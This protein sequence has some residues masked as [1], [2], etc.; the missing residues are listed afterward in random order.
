MTV[1]RI[2]EQLGGTGKGQMTAL[3]SFDHA[4]QYA[5]QV[6]DPFAADPGQEKDLE[7]YF[8]E[9]LA[10]PFVE[11]VRARNAA[12][13]IRRYG[14][15]LF[16]QIFADPRA[17]AA[18]QQAIKQGAH[19]IQVE[20]AGSPSF[21][22]LH[23]ETLYD[24]DLKLPLSQHA[25]FI[26]QNVSTQV[27]P[28]PMRPSPTINM[29]VVVARPSGSRDIGYRTV[30]RP[31]VDEL[32]KIRQPV[33]ITLLRPG[34]YAALQEHLEQRT[35]KDGVGYYHVIHF[36]VHGGLMS[37]EQFQQT[38]EPGRR[39]YLY[40]GRFGRPDIEPY[41]GQ[42][43]YLLLE[44]QDDEQQA[45]PVEASE[46]AKLLQ[47]H[48]IPI[49]VLNACQSG[50]YIGEQET[51]LG[52]H[53]I[54]AGVQTVLAMAYSVTV[55]A[56]ELL[57][58]MLYKELLADNSLAGALCLAR[59][60]LANRK[61][62]RAYYNQKIELE[63]WVLPIVYQNQDVHFTRQPFATPQQETAFYEGLA[64]QYSASQPTYGFIGR[65][66]DILHIER[67]L[68][69]RR[70]LLLIQGMGGAGKTTL[71]HHLAAWW[72]RTGLVQNVFYFGYDERAWNRQQL[73]HRIAQTVFGQED[74]A[75]FQSRS[76]EVQQVQLTQ[77]LRS[78]RHLLILD[79]LESITGA[80]LA[81]R[82]TLSRKEQGNLQSLLKELVGGQ[83]LVVLGSR[84]AET[85]L[86]SNTFEDNRYELA[87][88]DP[89]AASLLS[90]RILERHN[91]TQYRKDKDLPALLKLLDGFPL[92]LEVVLANLARQ[93][94]TQ[95]LAALQA[96]D[97]NLN[98]GQS[99]QR[100]ENILRCIDYSHSNL[101]PEA[102]NLLLCLAPFTSVIFQS[103]VDQ[104]ISILKQQPALAHFP[105]DRL[106]EVLQEAEQW[107]LLSPDPDQPAFLRL[108]PTLPYFLRNRLSSEQ[109]KEQRAAI[110][111]AF[112]EH[113]QE[114]SQS[115]GA[116]IQSKE[117]QKQQVGYLIAQFEYE[118][119]F[120]ALRFALREN[121]SVILIY[122]VLSLLLQRNQDHQH[123]QELDT[124]LLEN[125]ETLSPQEL[126]GPRGEEF[127]RVLGTAANRQL[128]L[129]QYEDAR[130]SYQKVLQI[131][132]KVSLEER[133][134]HL[135]QGRTYHQLGRVAE[136][137]RKWEEA[138]G[139]YERALQIK[140]EYQDGYSQGRTYHQ[141]GIVAQEQRKWEEAKG[142]YER[143][144]QIYVEY[145]DGY[146][147]A[148]TYH[149][150]G[151]VAQEQRKW[152]EAQGYYERALQIKIEYQDGYSQG[153]TYHQ[154]GIVAQEQRKWEEAKGYYERALRIFVEYDDNY[155]NGIVMRSLARLQRASN[156]AGFV[157]EVASIVGWTLE[158]VEEW[159]Q[160]AQE[161]SPAQDEEK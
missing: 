35:R 89:E 24:P 25:P 102:Q 48:Q 57:M 11:P 20:I 14:T 72:Q 112:R 156:D 71:L 154:L 114:L 140:I 129:K 94:P 21:Q 149:Q 42:K 10:F 142:Y 126:A 74:F 148:G 118:N 78:T 157:S 143:A 84:T 75:L 123:G 36:D 80:K 17:R 127:M 12:A 79:N 77:Q 39:F 147:Q 101:S 153:R 139:Y 19:T 54:R 124:M 119:L 81:I 133:E 131:I 98:I 53:L 160:K 125:L 82:H 145:Q 121:A 59:Q 33:E 37:Y 6:S 150:L 46:V 113:Y 51:S 56:V 40:R 69:T 135:L 90:E 87:G 83:T 122:G 95:I 32:R 132:E 7:W 5:I 130:A 8:E 136:E 26:R 96:G 107:G 50:K 97:V 110:E 64:R 23:W 44:G 99:E 49:A 41:T 45:D 88:L 55:S 67:R 76:P 128:N 30:S 141:L 38:P 115:I 91:A 108:Q 100:T 134:R 70:N 61:E 29:L 13:S 68:L 155:S 62:R 66:V 117:A 18:Y 4:V 47:Q 104:Y 144:L 93:T 109:Q 120:T 3:L 159:F 2:Q 86:A 52:N 28:A 16:G 138:Q 111:T 105:L 43:A 31:L 106:P 137:Q 34:T 15:N 152:E 27:L 73:M 92:A 158:E 65:D 60:A 9:Y 22:R 58:P 146:E 116:Y 1:L 161:D 63:D 151:R 85:W 103:A